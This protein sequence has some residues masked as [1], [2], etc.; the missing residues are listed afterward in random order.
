MKK[1]DLKNSFFHQQDGEFDWDSKTQG[2]ILG[3]FFWGY[4]IT[5]LPGAILSRKLGGGKIVFG[6][7]VLLTGLF[8]LL[9]PIAARSNVKTLILVR[10]MTGL[11]EVIWIST[12]K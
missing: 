1:T 4:T 9:T 3:S 11:A 7:G 8:S 6:M 12:I 2:L 5:Q 10:I